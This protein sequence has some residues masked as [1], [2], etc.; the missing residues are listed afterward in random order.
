MDAVR[1]CLGRV[2]LERPHARAM[3][4]ASAATISPAARYLLYVMDKPNN[5]HLYG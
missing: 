4:G 2:R 5:S 1:Q 3:G